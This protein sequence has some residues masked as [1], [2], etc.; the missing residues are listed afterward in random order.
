MTPF[1]AALPLRPKPKRRT[2]LAPLWATNSSPCLNAAQCGPLK[3]A[4]VIAPFETGTPRGSRMRVIE[5]APGETPS[6]RFDTKSSS[7]S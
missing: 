5:P 6:P 2:L 1:S 4:E 3:L 7:R